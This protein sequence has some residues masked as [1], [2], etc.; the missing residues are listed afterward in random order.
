MGNKDT[1]L[2]CLHGIMLREVHL[3]LVRLAGVEGAWRSSH[4]DDPPLEVVGDPVLEAGGR[5][6]LPLRELL[7]QAA[8]RDLAQRL[9]GRGRGGGGGA[10]HG[11]GAGPPAPRCPPGGKGGRG[12]GMG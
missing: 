7:L 2:R 10:R 12:L 1:D 6:D 4:I 3:Q 5:V 8:A 9:P 11:A